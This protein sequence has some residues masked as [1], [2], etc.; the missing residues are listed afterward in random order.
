MLKEELEERLIK[1]DEE[2]YAAFRNSSFSFTIVGGSAL[3]LNYDSDRGTPD[4]DV[5]NLDS[6]IQSLALKYDMN[7]RVNAFE[8]CFPYNY[9]DRLVEYTD[10][11]FKVCNFYLFFS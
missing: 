11:K 8:D 4:I 3:I 6:R 1:I 5:L 9:Q 7:C 10:Y 2:I